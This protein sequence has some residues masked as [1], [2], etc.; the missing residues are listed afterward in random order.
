MAGFDKEYPA[1]D[2]MIANLMRTSSFL[3]MIRYITLMSNI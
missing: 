2:T 3:H 1:S